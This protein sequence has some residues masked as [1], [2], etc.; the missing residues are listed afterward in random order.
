MPGVGRGKPASRILG[1]VDEGE[2]IIFFAH[3]ES[4]ELKYPL[5][6]GQSAEARAASIRLMLNLPDSDR[7]PIELR[8]DFP[9]RQSLIARISR[10]G[11]V[12]FEN[13]DYAPPEPAQPA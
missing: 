5:R 2:T 1:R 7:R 6:Y 3:P 10:E 9:A 13:L 12:A 11:A 4:K 8:L